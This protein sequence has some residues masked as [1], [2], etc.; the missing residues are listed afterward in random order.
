MQ[1]A[2]GPSAKQGIEE[3]NHKKTVCTENKRWNPVH[4]AVAKTGAFN[5]H[6]EGEGDRF[7]IRLHTNIYNWPWKS[8]GII[9]IH[10]NG[11]TKKEEVDAIS[12]IPRFPSNIGVSTR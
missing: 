3:G 1:I 7:P 12:N 4:Q 6:N 10:N 2:W 11:K 9:N 8:S 5:K